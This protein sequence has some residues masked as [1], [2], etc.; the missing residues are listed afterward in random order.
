MYKLIHRETLFLK[1]KNHKHIHYVS[2]NV[3]RGMSSQ[4]FKGWHEAD[5]LIYADW[6][7]KNLVFFSPRKE[8]INRNKKKRKKKRKDRRKK[9]FYI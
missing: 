8:I 3:N 1:T 5:I 9:L 7:Q 2:V 4:T 6:V